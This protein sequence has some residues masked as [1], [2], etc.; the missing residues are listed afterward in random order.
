VHLTPAGANSRCAFPRKSWLRPRS[1]SREPKP[2]RVGS[3]ERKPHI[4]AMRLAEFA[5]GCEGHHAAMLHAEPALPVFAGGVANV[6]CARIRF[7][8]KQLK[9][10]G[11]PL[12]S[13]FCARFFAAPNS[14]GEE[15]GMP[16]RARASSRTPS[17]ALRTMGAL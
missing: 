17:G 15:E 1:S 2:L 5:K 6:G 12:A 7:E 11:F 16:Q 4:A 13:S 9:S 14:A 8:A 10:T 3:I